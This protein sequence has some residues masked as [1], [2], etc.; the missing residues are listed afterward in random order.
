[1]TPVLTLRNE[2]AGLARLAAWVAQAR[3]F[4]NLSERDAFRVE[5]ALTEAVT[6]IIDNAF[7]GG[8][9]HDITVTVRW[10]AS[11]PGFEIT[12]D[13]IAFDPL[14]RPP[15]PPPATLGEAPIGGLGL[16]LIRHYADEC[17][18]VREAGLNRLHLGFRTAAA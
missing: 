3:A 10:G 15:A 7:P 5:L 1:M 12:D 11:G 2:R 13:G 4:G 17:R 14:S 8:G 9:P 16:A 6:N 18:Y